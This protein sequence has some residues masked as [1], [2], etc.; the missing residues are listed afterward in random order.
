MLGSQERFFPEG[1]SVRS[2]PK[3]LIIILFRKKQVVIYPP[4][5]TLFHEHNSVKHEETIL[6]NQR[7]WVY[8]G[9][10]RVI[11]IR[12]YP[13]F[14]RPH[15]ATFRTNGVWSSSS[16]SVPNSDQQDPT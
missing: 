14:I 3:K 11:C 1:E 15:T 2:G 10:T 12:S 9:R 6:S 16:G 5:V 13:V 8:L 4:L 7:C